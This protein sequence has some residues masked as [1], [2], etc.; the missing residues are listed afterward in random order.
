M[1]IK[2]GPFGYSYLLVLF[3]I[4]LLGNSSL[5]QA[6]ILKGFGKK[7]EKKIEQR[8][9]RKADR[10]VDK[11]LDK[12]DRKSD[13]G[14]NDVLNKKQKNKKAPKGEYPKDEQDGGAVNGAPGNHGIGAIGDNFDFIPGERVLFET[15]FSDA[16]IGNFP[17]NLEF[18]G[19]EL[20]VVS[21]GQGRAIAANS[22]GSFAVVLP[23][24]LPERFTMEFKQFNSDVGNK[25]RVELVDGNFKPLGKHF[26]RLEGY[27][28]RTGVGAY[29]PNGV[30]SL[31]QTQIITKELTP[32][33]I[34]VDGSYVKVYVGT[35][36]VAN[37]P[38]AELGRSKRIL[39]NFHDINQEPIYITD[40]RIAA[41]G[42]SLYQALEESGRVAI[43]D[44]LF[45]T[46]KAEILPESHETLKE[47]AELLRK[48]P[49]L[50]L[51]IE[52]HTD[53]TGNF[54]NNLKLS[55]QR[56][57]AVKT[58]LVEISKIAASRLKTMGLGQ[59]QPT[60]T[61]DTEAGRAKNRRVEIVKL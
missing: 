43:H 31:Q 20:S 1:K 19:G 6:Q 49:E 9:E 36:R 48:Y 11:T 55:A 3:G 10:H 2:N 13:E 57:A 23:Q 24:D 7:L 33:R 14:I 47:V 51:L 15:D 38:N 54:E 44:V 35:K 16:V 8:V 27:E 41:G 26:I 45:A 30:T 52:G 56:A 25:M 17:R 42:R 58:Y 32:I 50:H 46:G 29:G 59:S 39:F 18:R 60:T 34:M 4:F 5:C 28:M 12:A 37:M 40:I 21:Y 22:I 53:N 61:N